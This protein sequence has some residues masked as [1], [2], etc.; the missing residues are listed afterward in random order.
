MLFETAEK[1]L[2]RLAKKDYCTIHYSRTYEA[3]KVIEQ[4]CCL[5]INRRDWHNAST[6]KQAFVLLQEAIKPAPVPEDEAP[7]EEVKNDDHD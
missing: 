5:Y 7:T 6:W 3:G 4:E 1:K 2:K